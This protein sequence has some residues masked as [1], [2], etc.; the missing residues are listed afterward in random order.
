MMKK[1]CALSSIT[2]GLFTTPFLWAC[3][4]RPIPAATPSMPIMIQ[5]LPMPR[6]PHSS[7]ELLRA[8]WY[9]PGFVGRKTSSGEMF[10]PNALTAASKTLPLGSVVEVT[11][12]QN[13]KSIRVRVNDRGPFVPGRSLDLSRRAAERIGIIHRGVAPVKITTLVTSRPTW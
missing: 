8:S 4:A 7:V 9:G 10:N 2:T 12:P 6:P 11:N 5:P 1:R 13:G 3:V